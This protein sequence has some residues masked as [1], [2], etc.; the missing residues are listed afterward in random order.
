MLEV[1]VVI[2]DQVKE[3]MEETAAIVDSD[4]EA[5]GATEAMGLKAEVK[6]GQEAQVL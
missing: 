1:M 4:M 6:G 2:V 5:M 3:G